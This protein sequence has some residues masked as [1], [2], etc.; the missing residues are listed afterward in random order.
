MHAA[1]CSAV[2]LGN[3]WEFPYMAD[4]MSG[5]TFVLSYLLFMLII[6]MPILV[7]EW[8]I[9]RRGQKQPIHTMEDIAVSEGYLKSWCYRFFLI[10]I[11]YSVIGG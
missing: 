4:E 3:I 6:G 7:L 10:L 9:D 2:G 5:S 11:F 1:A 8:L